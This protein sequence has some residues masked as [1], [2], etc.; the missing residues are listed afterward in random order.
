MAKKKIKPLTAAIK[1]GFFGAIVALGFTLFWPSIHPV[2]ITVNT[3]AG[4][5]IAFVINLIFRVLKRNK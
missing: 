4:Y 2:T 3:I 5:A 1:F